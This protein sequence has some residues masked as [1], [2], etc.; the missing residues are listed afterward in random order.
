[1]ETTFSIYEFLYMLMM[2]NMLPPHIHYH[3]VYMHDI[4]HGS[5]GV[6]S[7]KYGILDVLLCE[8]YVV[9]TMRKSGIF[10]LVLLDIV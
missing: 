3:R 5:G 1:M 2:T 6:M 8:H 9:Q 4:A 7:K 10:A